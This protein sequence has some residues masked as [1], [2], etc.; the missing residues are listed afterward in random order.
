[1]DWRF[2]TIWFEQLDQS[3]FINVKCQKGKAPD[4]TGYEYVTLWGYKQ[5]NACLDQLIINDSMLYFELNLG[6]TKSLSGIESMRNLR[7]L[8]IHHCT[9]LSSDIGLGDLSGSLRHLHINTCKNFKFTSDLL[10]LTNLE[11]LRLNN[12][13]DID[14]LDFISCFPNLLD[15]RF[16]GTNV[17]SG[18]LTPLLKHKTLISVG[19]SD[20]RNFNVKS[21][22]I[23]LELAERKSS[24]TKEWIYKGEFCTFRYSNIGQ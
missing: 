20:K 8:E 12:C 18:D 16:V 7:R 1:M 2:N 6:G 9:K 10:K 22:R 13:G 15:F 3:K 23:E 24:F 14:N 11:V 19:L 4:L 21:E 5:N 17:V